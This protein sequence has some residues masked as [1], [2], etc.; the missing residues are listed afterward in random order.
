MRKLDNKNYTTRLPKIIPITSVTNPN[1]IHGIYPYRGKISAVDAISLIGQLKPGNLL[2]PFCGSGTIV[3]EASRA[4]MSAIGVDSNPLAIW[5]AKGKLASLNKNS[6]IYLNEA[7]KIMRSS[8]KSL[9]K[10]NLPPILKKAFHPKTAN[11]IIS[12]IPSFDK[13]SDYVKACLLGSIALTAPGREPYKN[14]GCFINLDS[15]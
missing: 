13:M 5:I 3:Y 15:I 2:D 4:G 6:E 11:E 7:S 14:K 12:V 8:Q 9:T 1:S 10:R